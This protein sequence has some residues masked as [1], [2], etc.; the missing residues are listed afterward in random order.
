MTDRFHDYIRD[1]PMQIGRKFMPGRQINLPTAPLLRLRENQL[2]YNFEK[3]LLARQQYDDSLKVAELENSAH[4]SG[5]DDSKSDATVPATSTA[6]FLSNEVLLP[7]KFAP[8]Q[9]ISP[10]K[11]K[12]K[13]ANSNFD[14]LESR[15]CSIFDDLELKTID[16]RAVLSQV[17]SKIAIN[18]VA[19]AN[20]E[21][22]RGKDTVS[23][24]T[25]GMVSF[26][27]H[28]KNGETPQPGRETSGGS[29]PQSGISNTPPPIPG[30]QSVAYRPAIPTRSPPVELPAIAQ[31]RAR[32]LA[33]GYRG[34]IVTITLE[35][36]PRERIQF[37]EYYM[38]GM[39]SLEKLDVNIVETLD[40]LVSCQLDDKQKISDYG[41]VAAQIVQMGFP[42]SRTFAAVKSKSGDKVAA[43]DSLLAEQR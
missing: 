19:S 17:L 21:V 24:A 9:T 10:A 14:D 23:L 5:S 39:R 2:T 32:L 12:S 3:E 38:K 25:N 13:N 8:P 36:L 1:M 20:T 11:E 18:P 6:G 16:D 28:T 41:S 33:K 31:L 43:L 27:A 4:S 22:C 42:A 34:N 26:S 37:I 35:R 29:T 15:G 40:F 30:H 7:S